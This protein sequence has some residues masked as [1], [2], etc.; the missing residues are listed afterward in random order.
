MLP[1]ICIKSLSERLQQ[2]A[3]RQYLLLLLLMV[4]MATGFFTASVVMQ[5]AFFA[6]AGGAIVLLALFVAFQWAVIFRRRVN[7]CEYSR[8]CAWCYLQ[9]NRQLVAI[10]LLMLAIGGAQFALQAGSGD[11]LSLINQY[12]LVFER[13]HDEPWRYL[14]GPFLHAGLVHWISNVSLLMVIAG[15][16]FAIG[17]A[18][19]IWLVFLSGVLLPSFILGFLPHWVSSDAFLGMSG[20]VFALYGWFIG[21]TIRHR[22]IFPSALGW[23]IAYFACATLV[24][25]SLLDPRS[26]WFVHAA[27]LLLG[28]IAG[29]LVFGLKIDIDQDMHRL[30][31]PGM[32]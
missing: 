29:F 31:L 9:P 6:K 3:L 26:S 25:S 13:A 32:P 11:I 30:Q 16:C 8:F 4:C 14:S 5:D 7:I 2:R 23:M 22:K 15:L 28:S 18:Y 27:G 24:V 20:G 10:A 19:A 12:G 17:R 1:P 21:L